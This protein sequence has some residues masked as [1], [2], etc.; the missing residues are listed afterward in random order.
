MQQLLHWLDSSCQVAV[1]FFLPEMFVLVPP[2][3]LVLR[4]EFQCQIAWACKGPGQRHSYSCLNTHEQPAVN[5]F[6]KT[7]TEI[8]KWWKQPAWLRG[9]TTESYKVIAVH[10]QLSPCTCIILYPNFKVAH[11]KEIDF[12]NKHFLPIIWG[13]FSSE[14]CSRHLFGLY[15]VVLTS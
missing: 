13:S 5:L 3:L 6:Q 2:A 15:S 8:A 12:F 10:V 7:M 9:Y 1:G 14:D 4:K 11:Q